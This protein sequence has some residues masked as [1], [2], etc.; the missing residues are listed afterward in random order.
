MT[1]PYLYYY[2]HK[3]DWQLMGTRFFLV[4]GGLLFRQASTTN[5]VDVLGIGVLCPNDFP[6][7]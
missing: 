3:L 7:Q 2:H 5:N 6:M 1:N 4:A